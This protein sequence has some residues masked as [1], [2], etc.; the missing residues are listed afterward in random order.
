MDIED[1]D[2]Q[3]K[4]IEEKQKDAEENLGD[5][6]IRDAILEKAQ[7]YE[8]HSKNEKAVEIYKEA[9]K[10]TIGI[11][12]KM[13]VWFYIMSI[14]IREKNL[15]K[16][17]ETIDACKKLLEE[18]GDWE[19]KNR[20]KIYEGI[21]NLLIR[22]LKKTSELFLDCISTFNYPDIISYQ[23]IVKYTILTSII[24]IGRSEMKKKVIHNSEVLSTIRELPDVKSLLDTYS[25]C[26]YKSFFISLTRVLDDLKT[27]E[28]LAP[29]RKFFTREIRIVIY[30]Q[31]LESYKT[32][33]LNSIAQAFG[34][35]VEF[36][37]KELSELISA[38]R[39][40]CKIDKVQGIVESERI[41]ERNNLYKTAVKQGD[42]LLNLVQKLS[43]VIDI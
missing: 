4:K 18:G 16:I 34:V 14:Y 3:L 40:T 37:D 42:H 19:R 13:D 9:L 35:S 6:E 20:L 36:I 41:D 17:L 1:F 30:S 8:K 7:L 21:Y 39:L 29:H 27:D 33:T 23:R 26:D 24:S 38:G 43:R 25:K 2:E 15:P 11:G 12:K 31:F 22:N 32:V 10:K 28:Y 5:V